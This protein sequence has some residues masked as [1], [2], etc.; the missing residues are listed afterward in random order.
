MCGFD[1]GTRSGD[2]LSGL[3]LDIYGPQKPADPTISLKYITEK[4]TVLGFYL[5]IA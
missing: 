3:I 2:R 4:L 1:W 5:L